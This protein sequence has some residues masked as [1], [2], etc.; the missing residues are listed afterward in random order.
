MGNQDATKFL[1]AAG[2]ETL[3]PLGVTPSGRG[4]NW[5]DDHGWWIVNV[6]F[7]PSGWS[8]GSYLNVGVQWLWKPYPGHS[9]EYGARV[10]ILTDG[11]PV[12]FVNFETE[13]QFANAARDLVASA[14]REVLKHRE[15]FRT[16]GASI[17][18]LSKQESLYRYHLAVAHG[19][20]GKDHEARHFFDAGQVKTRPRD[21]EVEQNALMDEL[22]SLARDTRAFRARILEIV[23][24]QRR[25]LKLNP[26]RV[27]V[28][29][30]TL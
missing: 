9:F 12:Q 23:D 29:P 22:S 10:P 11:K 30:G 16:L 3:T 15:Q 18:A 19:L 26:D 21:W 8:K 4:R 13:S 5:V 24:Q 20:V 27:V 1:L 25:D 14:A 6:E 2:R 28:L 17:K 7:Q